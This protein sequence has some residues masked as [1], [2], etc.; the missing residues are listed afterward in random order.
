MM[1]PYP[2][3]LVFERAKAQLADLKAEHDRFMVKMEE[4]SYPEGYTSALMAINEAIE[5]LK[6]DLRAIAASY[7]D[8]GDPLF[9]TPDEAF[10]LG[11]GEDFEEAVL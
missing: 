2:K 1:I 11:I 9:L 8:P 5:K 6:R 7:V 4:E 10:E 3:K